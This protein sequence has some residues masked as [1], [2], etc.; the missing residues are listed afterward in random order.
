MIIV[1]KIVFYICFLIGT[2]KKINHPAF[3][4]T[5]SEKPIHVHFSLMI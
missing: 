5:S 2:S 4:L 3:C 1:F